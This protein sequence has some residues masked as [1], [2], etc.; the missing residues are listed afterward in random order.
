MR[1]HIWPDRGMWVCGHR[2]KPLYW[3]VA[4][5]PCKALRLW[6]ECRKPVGRFG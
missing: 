3:T 5:L 1:P 2:D 6:L 4:D